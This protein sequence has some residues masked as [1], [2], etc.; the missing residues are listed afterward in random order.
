MG[1]FQKIKGLFMQRIDRNALERMFDIRLS[2]AE[3]MRSLA[4]LWLDVYGGRAPWVGTGREQV[5]NRLDFAATLCSDL[6]AKCVA[7]IA[8]GETG[9]AAFDAF[10]CDE[11]SREIRRQLECA[12]AGGAVAIRPYFDKARGRISLSWYA[13]DRFIPADWIGSRPMSGIFIDR[14]AVFE[15]G[16]T[17]YYT[18][19][20]GHKWSFGRPGERGSCK[21]S[22]KAFRSHSPDD[23]SS[24][25]EIPLSSYAKWADITPEAEARNLDAP[26][27]VYMK[28][29]FSN[30]KDIGS[31]AGVSVFKD[32]L[33]LLENIDRTYDA[34]CWELQSA[35][36]KVFVDASMIEVVRKANGDLVPRLDDKEK[37]LYKVMDAEGAAG[38]YMDVYSPAIRQADITAALKT[39]I[40]LL[41][42]AAHLDSGFYVYDENSG[43]VVAKQHKTYQTICDIQNFCVT[44]ALEALFG[45]MKEMQ[46][47][48]SLPVFTE[49]EISVSYGDSIMTDE[50][51]E[52]AAAQAEV[53]GGLRSRMSY[54]MEYR[55]LT[56]DEAREELER[57]REESAALAPVST[58]FF[59]GAASEG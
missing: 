15:G 54:L 23:L 14:D 20:E 30:N 7:E 58:G 10:W 56:E 26:L 4:A 17:V 44:P 57:M 24:A 12:L 3:D 59:G 21:I 27:F 5:L 46:A 6:S 48:Y 49:S 36:N 25:R 41:C 13:A 9:D 33:P 29:P 18:K 11:V 47:L 37:R 42:G 45:A 2:E 52:K 39:Q 19:L 43:E 38:R 55:N 53:Q 34:L 35:Q 22:V 28:T 16:T 51:T 50:E 40:S 1:I 32:A 31:S 8:V